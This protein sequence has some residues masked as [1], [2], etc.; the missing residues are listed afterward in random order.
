MPHDESK[1]DLPP[2]VR[3]KRLPPL[4]PTSPPVTPGYQPDAR[5]HQTL[6]P[7]GPNELTLEMLGAMVVAERIEA[8]APIPGIASPRASSPTEKTASRPTTPRSSRP[9]SSTS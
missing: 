5:D 4:P 9:R 6:P 3:D 2:L 1:D 8:N 7:P